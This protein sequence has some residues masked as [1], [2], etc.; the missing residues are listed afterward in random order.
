[1]VSKSFQT[2]LQLMKLRTV[3]MVWPWCIST[4]NCCRRWKFSTMNFPTL[5]FPT[6]HFQRLIFS[7]LKIFNVEFFNV[8]FFN[9]ESSRRWFFQRWI[10]QRWIFRASKTFFGALLFLA[11]N[12]SLAFTLH[13]SKEMD[14]S[15]FFGARK[16]RCVDFIKQ[17]YSKR[18]DFSTIFDRGGGLALQI[19]ISR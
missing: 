3:K 1:M 15:R 18:Y 17:T 11:S 6:I 7:T 12:I 16:A 9:V 10:F 4:L 8:D 2:R 19:S 13:L 5:K 14:A